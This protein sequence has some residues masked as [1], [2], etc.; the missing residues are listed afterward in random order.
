MLKGVSFLGVDAG[1]G[2]MN[3][4]SMFLGPAVAASNGFR[5]EPTRPPVKTESISKRDS[6]GTVPVGWGRPASCRRGSL[7]KRRKGWVFNKV[8]KGFYMFL[9][10]PILANIVE[11]DI[12]GFYAHWLNCMARRP[13]KDGIELK[14]ILQV[15]LGEFS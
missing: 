3:N 14:Q 6:T 12:Q 15:A 11:I 4:R 5:I 1:F 8:L 13:S 2:E 7:L 10:R 9:P